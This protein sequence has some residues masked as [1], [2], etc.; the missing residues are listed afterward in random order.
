MKQGNTGRERSRRD[1]KGHLKYQPFTKLKSEYEKFDRGNR[2]IRIEWMKRNLSKKELLAEIHKIMEKGKIRNGIF[3]NKRFYFV[4]KTGK[5]TYLEVSDD[6]SKKLEQGAV[7][8]VELPLAK[9][10]TFIIVNRNTAD[11]IAKLDNRWIR[12]WNK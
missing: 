1:Y 6:I 3:G 9:T 8:I 7:A 11:T 10:E 2:G 12:F 4:T 5:I